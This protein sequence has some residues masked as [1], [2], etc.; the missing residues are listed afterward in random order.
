MNKIKD[1]ESYRDWPEHSPALIAVVDK[2]AL[3]ISPA[4]TPE[5]HRRRWVWRRAFYYHHWWCSQF[6]GYRDGMPF[7]PTQSLE[8]SDGPNP[9]S[10]IGPF[11]LPEGW[12]T[13]A[14]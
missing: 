10:G 13:A 7:S 14:S 3:Q 2:L 9:L 11:E 1:P 5:K 4:W 8:R 12:R 6:P